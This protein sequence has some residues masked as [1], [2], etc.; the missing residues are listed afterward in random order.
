MSV[1]DAVQ[2]HQIQS[3]FDFH[4]R[5]AIYH[6]SGGPATKNDFFKNSVLKFYV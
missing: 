6:W 2:L 5:S 1:I 3:V 4:S